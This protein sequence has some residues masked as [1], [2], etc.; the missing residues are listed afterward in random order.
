MA[1]R[2]QGHVWS[3]QGQCTARLQ[4]AETHLLIQRQIALGNALQN[5]Q[6]LLGPVSI[7]GSLRSIQAH[8]VGLRSGILVGVG[9][10]LLG[11][12]LGRTG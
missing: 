8:E 12:G 6:Y 7:A 4:G 5:R 11:G 10:N 1:Q 9:E 3:I 2:A